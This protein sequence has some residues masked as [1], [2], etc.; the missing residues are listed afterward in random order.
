M[1]DI[2]LASSFQNQ[3]ESKFQ[4]GD[5]W[6]IPMPTRTYAERQKVYA[7]F[8]IYNLNKN[9]FGR[10]SYKTQYN[11][12]SSSLPSV[13][14]FGAVSSGFKALF[15]NRKPSFSI[16]TEHSGSNT[17]LEV[18]YVEI[19]LEKARPGTNALEIRVV[20]QVTGEEVSRQVKFRYGN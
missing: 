2:Q 12:R 7:Y 11:V 15:R 18:E 16:E 10:T 17:Q 8:E 9:S 6:I 13:G 19:D 14:V 5:I 4:K 20:D 3:G 1:S